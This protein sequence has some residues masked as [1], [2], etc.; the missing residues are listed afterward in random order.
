MKNI[1]VIIL[2]F[3]S[4]LLI[5]QVSSDFNYQ[6]LLLSAA[7]SGVDGK[8]V[9]FVVSI[10]ADVQG[11]I[12]YY[13][14]AQEVQTDENGI[15]NFVIGEGTPLS[16]SMGDVD[17]L[18]SVPYLD[19]SYDLRDGEGDRFLG[20]TSFSAVPFA[21]YSKYIYCL[22]GEPGVR[23]LNGPAGEVGPQGPQGAQGPAGWDGQQGAQGPPGIPNM[24]ILDE[25]PA[26]ALE[27]T[28]Y[29]DDGTNRGDSA[30][31]FRYY[32]GSDWLD[33]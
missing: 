16:G 15:F 13:S 30:P 4:H 11:S 17:W 9:D 1:F 6:G 14:E 23:G 31:G 29:L 20:V 18:G 5:G 10:T 32:D 19:I 26:N 33:L 22:P 2:L 25:A 21:L 7:G 27:G 3:S 28:V 8:L 24:P 12:A